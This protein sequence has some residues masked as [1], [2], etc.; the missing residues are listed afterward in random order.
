LPHV[1]RSL[2]SPQSVLFSSCDRGP[3]FDRHPNAPF[4]CLVPSFFSWPQLSFPS[5]NWCGAGDALDSLGVRLFRDFCRSIFLLSFWLHPS[6][7]TVPYPLRTSPH[8]STTLYQTTSFSKSI[9][10]LR[11]YA[12]CFLWFP[13]FLPF[14]VGYSPL[15]C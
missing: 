7:P 12:P 13:S 11:P 8:I 9:P 1:V 10:A 2:L 14:S 5:L 15:F 6:S 4:L 3:Q